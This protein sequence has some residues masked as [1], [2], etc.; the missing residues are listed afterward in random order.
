MSKRLTNKQIKQDIREDEI[1]SVLED[2]F[3]WL[4]D[5]LRLVVGL[6]VGAL[7]AVLL[8]I[9]G[10]AVLDSR[11]A[12]AQEQLAEALEVVRAPV[13]ADGEE[14]PEGVDLSFASESERRTKAKEALATVKGG[15]AGEIASLHLADIALEEGDAAEA[16]KLWEGYLRSNSDHVL[17]LAV[18][19]NLLSLDRKE[20]KAEAVAE[21]LERELTSTAKTLP[22]DVILYELGQTLEQLGR[23]DEAMDYYQRI[24]DDYP[25]SSY[26]A[27]A[28][29]LVNV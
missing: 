3:L 11:A 10:R 9:G 23:R 14:V 24:L 29:E 4:Q 7:V 22:E 6:A 16:R 13:L 17:T 19:L 27:K 15:K 8:F 21:T 25:R 28:R 26:T 20:G 18:R 5:N 2:I 12:A 1:R